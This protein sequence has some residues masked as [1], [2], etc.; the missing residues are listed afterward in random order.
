MDSPCIT[1]QVYADTEEK[2]NAYV[3][4]IEQCLKHSNRTYDVLYEMVEIFP[5]YDFKID[6]TQEVIENIKRGEIN[7]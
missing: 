2:Y 6:T 3:E 4:D 1:I 7:D 5:I